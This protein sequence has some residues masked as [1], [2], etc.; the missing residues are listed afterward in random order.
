[1][2]SL[3]EA[4]QFEYPEQEIDKPLKHITLSEADSIESYKFKPFEY[5]RGAVTKFA[6]GVVDTIRDM[7]DLPEQL[8]IFGNRLSYGYGGY[9]GDTEA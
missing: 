5:E 8:S 4:E 3:T 2:I 6:T 1:M 7:Q 9:F